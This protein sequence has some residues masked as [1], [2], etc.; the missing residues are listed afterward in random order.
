MIFV[1]FLKKE[2]LWRVHK[3]PREKRRGKPRVK[4]KER[5]PRTKE[6]EEGEADRREGGGKSRATGKRC[7]HGQEGR[8]TGRPKKWTKDFGSEKNNETFFL[9]LSQKTK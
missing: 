2:C 7:N 3:A 5:K 9:F 8:Q 6:E 4:K 1:F